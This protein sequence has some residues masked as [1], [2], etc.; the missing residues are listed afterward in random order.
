MT[1]P[2][3][4]HSIEQPVEHVFRLW[5]SDSTIS[6]N[7]WKVLRVPPRPAIYVP[8]P[9]EI[10]PQLRQ[11]LEREGIHALYLHQKHAWDEV[12]AGKSVV[13]ATGTASGK[14]L[15]F[16]L[17]VLNSC[18]YQGNSRA[19]YIY[20]TKALAQDQYHKLVQWL[21]GSSI[22]AAIYDGDTPT[23]Q[24]SAIRSRANIVLTN[25]D[26]LHMGI[27]P[28]HTRWEALFRDLRFVVIDEVHT[29][30]GVFGSHLANL[31]R[32]L[33]RI[34]RFYGSS[35]Q[36]IFTSATIGN[37]AEHARRLAEQPVAMIDDDGAPQGE[38]FFLIYNPP[39]ID[40]SLGIR[41]S[42]MQ[43]SQRLLRDLLSCEIQ[44]IVFARTRRLVEI[45]RKYIS[46]L[47]PQTRNRISGYRSG[48]LPNERRKIE[49]GL[50]SGTLQT[51]ITTNALELGIDIGSMDASV[52]VGF[53]GT[54]ASFRQQ[55]GRAGRTDSPSIAAL[56]AS[57]D[58]IDQFLA[59]HPDYLFNRSPEQALIDPNNPLILFQQLECAAFELPFKENERFGNLDSK[60]LK[61]ILEILSHSGKLHLSGGRYFWV[62][63]QY[64]ASQVSLRNSSPTS[65]KLQVE[66][67]GKVETIGIVDRESAPWMVHPGAVYLHDGSSYLVNTLDLE[68]NIA[69]LTKKEVD[70]Y[71]KPQIHTEIEKISEI[72]SETITGGQKFYGEIKVTTQVIGFKQIRWYTHENL[73]EGALNLP[74]SYLYTTGYWI[75]LNTETVDSLRNS[76]LWSNDPNDY[77]PGW[78]RIRNE[79]RARDHFTCQVCGA[80]E[81]NE[82]H[83]V[84][85]KIPF[86]SFSS[87]EEANR[88][89]NLIT[90]CKNCHR[91]VEAN[92]RIKS[93][94]A[95]MSYLFHHLTPLFLMCDAGDLGASSDPQSP[96]AG[97]QPV[98]VIYD[99]MP[100]GIGLSQ[101]LFEIDHLVI[102]DAIDLITSCPCQNGCPSC[103]GPGGENGSGGKEETLAILQK[104][105]DNEDG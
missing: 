98:V 34:A 25:P 22:T 93:G 62:S 10:H 92:L 58:P 71:T 41:A 63:E 88:P 55:A 61:E 77:G 12:L 72:Q 40:P 21:E 35:P 53:P 44:T 18:F 68:Q 105:M 86:R 13:I 26:M 100:G 32:R 85:H 56:V 46:D 5:N 4:H 78:N 38:K 23:H 64:P 90:L 28:H 94:L 43:E 49:K 51:V 73:G 31:L 24:R 57:S 101:K 36:F 103:V 11:V 1:E 16:N 66:L 48:Y 65:V 47:N 8:L 33:K 79:I 67:D 95:G 14:T 70:Y 91:L 89:H 19:L 81:K 39:V 83:H 74:P 82:A 2:L 75:S 29:Y 7:I 80:V 104:L 69:W 87:A 15:C 6:Q 102:K 99:Q 37:P 45:L 17:P 76:G 42:A 9:D 30:R 50:R 27:L 97:N 59:R 60:I 84:H 20:P 54:I 3:E 52:I 96:L